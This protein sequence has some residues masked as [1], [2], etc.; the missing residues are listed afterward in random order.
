MILSKPGLCLATCLGLAALLTAAQ[1]TAA[2]PASIGRAIQIYSPYAGGPAVAG[3]HLLV[4]V[5]IA[6]YRLDGMQ[7]NRPADPN[8]GYWTLRVDG[9][10]AGLAVS[11]MLM[12]PNAVLPRLA[13]GNH[14][15]RVELVDSRGAPLAPPVYQEETVALANDMVFDPGTSGPPAAKII[16]PAAGATVAPN[17][18]FVK[19]R[20]NNF[21]PDARQIGQVVQPGT[22]TWWVSVDGAF[23]GL[24]MSEIIDLPNDALPNIAPGPHTLAVSLHGNDGRLLPGSIGDSIQVTVNG[25]CAGCPPQAAVVPGCETAGGQVFPA[26]GHAVCGRFLAWWLRYGGL[27]QFG[28]PIT[29]AGPERDPA[30]G[31]VYQVQ[32]FQRARFE[33]HPEYAGTPSEVLLGRLGAQVHPP[34]PPAPARRT[35]G[36]TYFPATG[37]NVE[38]LF[39]GY[40]QAHGGLFVNGYPIS[41]AIQERSPTDGQIYTVQ[42]FERARYEYHPEYANGPGEVLLGLLGVQVARQQ[43]LLAGP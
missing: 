21:R 14:R 42:Y 23:A 35:T 30:S 7:I 12:A 31:V 26:T 4:Q 16:L 22:G 10:E 18:L 8:T 29:D 41:E 13:A 25:P 3:N 40:W 17:R 33:Y 32:Y 36:I 2:P 1:A 9:A 19:V 11:D 6:E 5:T 39:L 24:S 38:P 27:A 20:L 37:H 15:I 43:G 34:D 28:Y